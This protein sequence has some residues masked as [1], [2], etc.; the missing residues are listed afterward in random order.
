MSPETGISAAEASRSPEGEVRRGIEGDIDLPRWP[1][2]SGIIKK[3]TGRRAP[4]IVIVERGELAQAPEIVVDLTAI[5]LPKRDHPFKTYP[6]IPKT[7][8]EELKGAI[9]ECF[10]LPIYGLK[11]FSIPHE[12]EKAETG[13]QIA[14]TAHYGQMRKTP[15]VTVLEGHIFLCTKMLIQFYEMIG[16]LVTGADLQRMLTHDVGED[17]RRG[18]ASFMTS[19]TLKNR[20]EPG[21]FSSM[22]LLTKGFYG[23]CAGESVPEKKARRDRDYFI[24]LIASGDIGAIYTKLVEHVGN[25]RS[26]HCD[27]TP[28]KGPRYVIETELLFLP[29]L[30][31]AVPHFDILLKVYQDWLRTLRDHYGITKS[32]IAGL[33]ESD[34]AYLYHLKRLTKERGYAIGEHDCFG[35]LLASPSVKTPFQPKP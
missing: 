35:Q 19:A 15:G 24:K 3:P 17:Q 11:G 4:R 30:K 1:L 2:R 8:L 6:E 26:L 27:P 5:S 31:Q 10:G 9:I 29:L 20:L 21:V 16:Q 28:G 33:P 34:R 25:L 14:T 12:L 7:T 32:T 13:I 18:S 23:K 22:Q